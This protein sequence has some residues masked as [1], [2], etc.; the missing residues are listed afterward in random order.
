MFSYHR[1][2]DGRTGK[3]LCSLCTSSPVAAG[4]EQAAV[5]RPAR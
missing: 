4:G 1:P 5:G 3:A 2:I